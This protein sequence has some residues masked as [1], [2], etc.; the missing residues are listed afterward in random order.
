M[1]KRYINIFYSQISDQLGWQ[2]R[3]LWRNRYERKKLNNR[4]FT[5]FS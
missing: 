1:V 4:D 2:S 5:I 3:K